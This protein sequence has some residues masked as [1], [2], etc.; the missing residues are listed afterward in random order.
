MK[1][2][3]LKTAQ[4]H[5]EPEENLLL[6]TL[7]RRCASAKSYMGAARAKRQSEGEHDRDESCD[8]RNENLHPV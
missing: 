8:D 3:M 7:R 2:Q 5:K 1:G 4:P 6:I